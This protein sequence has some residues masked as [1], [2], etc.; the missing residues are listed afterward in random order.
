LRR[1]Q[2][3]RIV[4]VVRV[5]DESHGKGAAW[6]HADAVNPGQAQR[7]RSATDMVNHRQHMSPLVSGKGIGLIPS[8]KNAGRQPIQPSGIPGGALFGIVDD[9]QAAVAGTVNRT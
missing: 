7:N 9:V 8:D 2:F 4:G 6:I 1:S 5:L 3:A